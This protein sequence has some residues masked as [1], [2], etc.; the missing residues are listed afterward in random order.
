MTS[1]FANKAYRVDIII[2]YHQPL[3]H[4]VRVIHALVGLC[5]CVHVFDCYHY[6]AAVCNAAPKQIKAPMAYLER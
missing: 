3:A 2:I 4:T 6:F 1:K 5:M